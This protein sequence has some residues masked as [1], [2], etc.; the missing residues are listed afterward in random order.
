METDCVPVLAALGDTMTKA[1]TGGLRLLETLAAAAAAAKPKVETHSSPEA[2]TAF[3]QSE[4]KTE[5]SS[6]GMV[7]NRGG[8]VVEKQILA[9]SPAS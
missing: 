9:E 2:W 1:A 4:L 6:A 8:K 3:V 5:A 7:W